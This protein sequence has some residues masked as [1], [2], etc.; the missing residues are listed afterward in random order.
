MEDRFMKVILK[1]IL[2]SAEAARLIATA[3][4]FLSRVFAVVLTGLLL[5]PI[6]LAVI[7]AKSIHSLCKKD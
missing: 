5:T 4:M 1:F 7:A 2:D 3:M 6:A